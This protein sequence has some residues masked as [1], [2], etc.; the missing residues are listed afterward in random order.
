LNYLVNTSENAW[1]ITLHT[2]IPTGPITEALTWHVPGLYRGETK[3]LEIRVLTPAFYSRFVHYAHTS[4]AFDRECI[5]T[6]EK[7]RTLWIS[8]PQLLPALLNKRASVTADDAIEAEAAYSMRSRLDELRWKLLKKLRCPPASPAYAVSTPSK[9]EFTTEDVRSLP[10]S[11][12]DEFVRIWRNSHRAGAYRRS[13]TKLFLAER[14]GFGFA[15]VLGLIDLI[16]RTTLCWLAASQL[17]AM[18]ARFEK[19]DIGGCSTKIFRD[20]NV[21]A[22]CFMEV[23]EMLHGEW[24]WLVGTMIATSACHGYGLMK[25]YL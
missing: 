2:A 17:V 18:R 7:N 4:E 15:E 21:S 5:F 16:V 1:S 22:A 20:T 13:V 24:W 11:A 10:Y 23:K 9:A 6:D 12:C 3:K 19:A 25:G 14:F 8:Q